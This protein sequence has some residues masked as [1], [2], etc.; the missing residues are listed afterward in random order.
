V[1]VP[2]AAIAV[3]LRPVDEALRHAQLL[4]VR[5]AD[6]VRSRAVRTPHASRAPL[7]LVS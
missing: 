4:H 7:A 3:I 6:E 1:V 5:L 2:R